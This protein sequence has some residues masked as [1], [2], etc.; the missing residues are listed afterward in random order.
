MSLEVL[1][2]A[3]PA[4]EPRGGRSFGRPDVAT[5]ADI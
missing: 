1:S 5:F 4:V 2:C 3:G